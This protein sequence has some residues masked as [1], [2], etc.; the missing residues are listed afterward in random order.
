MDFRSEKES[1]RAS[2]KARLARMSTED[3]VRESRSLC[4]R[5]IAALP[6][7]PG[8]ICV[9]YPMMGSEADIKELFPI[10]LERGWKIFFP[11][12]ETGGFSFRQA[13]AL[14]A[15][16][17]GRYGLMEPTQDDPTLSITDVTLALLPG[18]AFDHAGGRIG[19]GNGGYDK[20]L[21]ELRAKNPAA[22]VWGIALECQIVA[23]VPREAHDQT[24]D[25]VVTPRGIID[26]AMPGTG[27]R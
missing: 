23:Q 21:K 2:I 5:L 26:P 9:F 3:R 19:R 10:L 27:P 16:V 12:F 17:P 6:A 24:V 1:L 4:K 7:E 25:L 14:T 13:E 18:M 20:W 15:L 11:R 8:A 22:K